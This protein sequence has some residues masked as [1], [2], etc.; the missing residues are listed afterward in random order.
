MAY[1]VIAEKQ[2]PSDSLKKSLS[3]GIEMF[4]QLQTYQK[5]LKVMNPSIGFICEKII[6]LK[7]DLLSSDECLKTIIHS[8]CVAVSYNYSDPRSNELS[9]YFLLI[10]LKKIT[11]AFLTWNI[12]GDQYHNGFWLSLFASVEYLLKNKTHIPPNDD[13][14][15]L[16]LE[17]FKLFSLAALKF[18]KVQQFKTVEKFWLEQLENVL[19]INKLWPLT[20]DAINDIKIIEKTIINENFESFRPIIAKLKEVNKI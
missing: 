19:M 15:R 13:R 8:C 7:I 14:C 16:V 20:V 18:D 12:D 9:P 10:N 3:D 2:K 5:C 17:M 4:F 1:F 11:H 6:L